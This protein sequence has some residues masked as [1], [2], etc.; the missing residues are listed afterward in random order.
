MLPMKLHGWNP[1]RM[2]IHLPLQAD[3][4]APQKI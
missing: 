1:P 3:L 2:L 4:L